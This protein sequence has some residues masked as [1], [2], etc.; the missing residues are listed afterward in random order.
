[1]KDGRTSAVRVEAGGEIGNTLADIGVQNSDVLLSDAVVFVE[2]PSDKAVIETWSDKLGTSLADLNI[3][4][5]GAGHMAGALIGG[6]VKSKLVPAK[7]IIAARRSPAG[8]RRPRGR[9]A[10]G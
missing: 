5:I 1:M 4:V 2:G 6:M 8:A 3:T 9:G 10:A 7:R